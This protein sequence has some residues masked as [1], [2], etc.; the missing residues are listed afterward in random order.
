[1]ENTLFKNK[2][3]A[4]MNYQMA[5][6]ILIWAFERRSTETFSMVTVRSKMELPY[7]KA[8]ELVERMVE[9]GYLHVNQYESRRTFTYDHLGMERLMKAEA[10]AEQPEFEFTEVKETDNKVKIPAS[11]LFNY[12]VKA[13]AAE[14]NMQPGVLE[15]IHLELLSCH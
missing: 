14:H 8:A 9:D 12:A 10:I 11:R 5:L 7:P 13:L 2:R 6:D 1:M 4:D 3:M 15:D